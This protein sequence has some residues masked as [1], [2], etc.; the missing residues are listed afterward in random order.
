M[1][2]NCGEF[3]VMHIGCSNPQSYYSLLGNEILR[4]D[5]EEDFGII[6]SKDLKFTKQ[7]IEAEKKSRKLVGY[8]KKHFK[9][10]NRHCTTAVHISSKTPS[11]IQSKKSDID[12][13][14]AV[15]A[16]AT[17]LV[18]TLRQFGYR[19]RMECLNLFDLQTRRLRGQLMETFE[20]PRGITHVDHNNLFMLST[21]Q[22]RGKID[23][24]SQLQLK[25]ILIGECP[26]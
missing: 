19:Q 20:I 2:S 21:N 23:D 16:R 14:E 22:S 9:Y 5:Q 1:P 15:Q 3:K 24:K 11:K 10:I 6:I 4:V 17:K 13:L 12:R 7:S 26:N 18:P 8:I 25:V